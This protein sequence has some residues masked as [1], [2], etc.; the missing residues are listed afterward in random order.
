MYC[1]DKYVKMCEK[2]V[3][4][5]KKWKIPP[6]MEGDFENDILGDILYYWS[7]RYYV[8]D[9]SNPI[10]LPSQE[11]LQNMVFAEGDGLQYRTCSIYTFSTSEYGIPLTIDGIMK[12]LLLAYVMY[13]K[14]K[15]QWSDEDW[16]N[17]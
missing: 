3:K 10:F 16:I 14:Y 13:E 12:E 4:I 6:L 5:Q 7:F 2:A 1:S 15:K 9:R 17:V 8:K 11:Q